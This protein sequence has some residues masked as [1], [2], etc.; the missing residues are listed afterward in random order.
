[1]SPYNTLGEWEPH[2]PLMRRPGMYLGV[3]AIVL[4]LAIVIIVLLIR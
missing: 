2:R 1:M 4:I 3:G